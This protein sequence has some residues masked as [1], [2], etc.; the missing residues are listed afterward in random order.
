MNDATRKEI[1]FQKDLEGAPDEVKCMLRSEKFQGDTKFW[2]Q[3]PAINACILA[4]FHIGRKMSSRGE[5]REA[6]IRREAWKRCIF[7][8]EALS[9]GESV[10]GC[11]GVDVQAA[12]YRMLMRFEKSAVKAKA[13]K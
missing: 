11:I 12:Y 9:R 10:E 7:E 8:F 5:A 4:A 6:A 1:A 3:I 2:K 13:Q